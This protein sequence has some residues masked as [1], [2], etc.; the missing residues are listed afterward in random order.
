MGSSL[1]SLGI[2]SFMVAKAMLNGDEEEVIEQYVPKMLLATPL[3]IGATAMFAA[4]RLGHSTIYDPEKYSYDNINYWRDDRRRFLEPYV[5]SLG[6]SLGKGT[7]S[8]MKKGW[9][10]FRY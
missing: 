5:S 1:I 9:Y 8:L 7:W 4:G 10:E 2:S 6:Y 3:G